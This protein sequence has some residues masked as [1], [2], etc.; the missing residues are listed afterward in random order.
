MKKLIAVACAC[1]L[2]FISEAALAND[3]DDV[4][5]AKIIAQHTAGRNWEAQEIRQVSEYLHTGSRSTFMYALS[6]MKNRDSQVREY[7]TILTDSNWQA[8]PALDDISKLRQSIAGMS[9]IL[10]HTIALDYG[11]PIRLGNLYLEY[12]ELTVFQLAA[13]E[14]F[15]PVYTRVWAYVDTGCLQKIETRLGSR[16]EMTLLYGEANKD[17]ICLPV[18]F[19]QS[20]NFGT[21]SSEKRSNLKLLYQDWQPVTNDKA[22]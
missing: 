14:G 6:T 7:E 15:D 21:Y 19:N 16:I 10:R 22:P 3:K 2:V 13:S 8:L 9:T 4:L 12:K 20:S 11:K 17:G 5:W 18:E 1:L